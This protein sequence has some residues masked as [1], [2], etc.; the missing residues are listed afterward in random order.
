MSYRILVAV[1]ALLCLP[2]T[3]TGDDSAPGD[4]TPPPV[5]EGRD[6]VQALRDGGYVLY[7]RHGITDHQ[8]N[9]V[10]RVDLS[11]CA[12]QRPLSAEGRQQMREV[13]RAIKAL[14]IHV[15]TVLSSP[16]C[17]CVDTAELAFGPAKVSDLLK[18]TVVADE[19][20]VKLRAGALREMLGTVPPVPGTNT[21]I[22]GHTANLQDAT[23]IWPKPEGV[24]IVFQPDGNGDFTFVAR[25]PSGDWSRLALDYGP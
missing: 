9:D 16:Y 21:V 4:N 12:T 3:A 20:T 18:H 7:F 24:A 22:A 19:Q 23:G 5:L 25:V 13:G 2:L 1:W 8:R 6:L 11:N 17:R 10:D 14:G 15:S